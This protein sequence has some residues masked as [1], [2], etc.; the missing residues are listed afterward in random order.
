MRIRRLR[1]AAYRGIEER[2]LD[3][4]EHGVTIVEGP[5]EIGKSS[6]VEALDIVFRYYDSTRNKNV[7]AVQ[8]IDKDVGTE[9]EVDVESGPYRFTL[10]KRFFRR[11]ETVLRIHAPRAQTLKGRAA[12]DRALAILEE[13]IDLDLW[14]AMQVRQDEPIGQAPLHEARSLAQALDRVAGQEPAGDREA[15]LFLRVRDEYATYFSET[16]L[17]RKP[18]KEAAE[19]VA[20]A[21]ERRATIE[22]ELLGLERDAERS[23]ELRR[24]IAAAAEELR[25]RVAGAAERERE[26]VAIERREGDV[27]RL[28]LAAK[29]EQMHESA[30]RNAMEVR[31]KLV[32][33]AE[34]AAARHR[35][36]AADASVRAP[37]LCDAD[38]AARAARSRVAETEERVRGAQAC[39]DV[40][41]SDF[42]YERAR[43]SY[44]QLGERWSRIDA[45]RRRA[46][47]A[48]ALLERARVD[49]E[50]LAAIEARQLAAVEAQ[51]RLDAASPR[52][53]VR[54]DDAAAAGFAVDV[55]GV[56]VPLDGAAEVERTIAARAEVRA[57]GLSLTVMAGASVDD[58]VAARDDARDGLAALLAAAD[59][60]SVAEARRAHAERAEAERTIAQA[61]RIVEENLRDLSLDAL[62]DKR[63]RL[64]AWVESY[65]EERPSEPAPVAGHDAAYAARNEAKAA[66]AERTAERDAAR[67]AA[68]EA[69]E[70]A[71]R[72]RERAQATN[73]KL[74]LAAENARTAEEELAAARAQRPDAA[75][76]AELAGAAARAKEADAHY[77]GEQ[78]VLRSGEPERVRRREDD[79]RRV[80]EG[81]AQALRRAEDEF[82]EVTARLDL[83][84]EKGLYD[85]LQEA[86]GEHERL[87]EENGAVVRRAGAARVLYETMV[88]ERDTARR[89][90]AAP[91]RE[92]IVRL[93]GYVFDESLRVE[94]DEEL[95]IAT[96]T[97]GGRTLAFQDLSAG[98]REQLSLIGRLACARL[99]DPADGVPVIFDDTLGHSDPARLEGMGALL[100]KAGETNQVIVLTCTPGRFRSVPGAHVIRL[101]HAAAPHAP[102]RNGHTPAPTQAQRAD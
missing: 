75:L 30:A 37:A 70:R 52:L 4:P 10:E 50:T 47:E 64:R 88:A 65:P 3:F 91:L 44:D 51:A 19:A 17:P 28:Q 99:V 90:Y 11:P 2:T 41:E 23:A 33:R 46:D 1:L 78:E 72:L 63:E 12:H 29:A 21:D 15:S 87:R 82:R 7:L 86:A 71:D 31:R 53:R 60:A 8:P 83:L 66:L 57:P 76:E 74:K 85:A 43:L 42:E 49:D 67:R 100:A 95:R 16:G 24:E 32:A 54:A 96:R 102:Q 77:R 18:L 39:A 98:A 35:D 89:A 97:L 20:A 101:Q 38:E 48:R 69:R 68:E 73:I 5:N 13:T 56:A 27:Q 25:A 92:E 14:R 81:A 22:R 34:E 58:L 61:E 26:R 55:D 84:G 62:Q 93:A 36:L 59:V 94:L 79:A 6:I 45:A 9:I 80:A 40:R